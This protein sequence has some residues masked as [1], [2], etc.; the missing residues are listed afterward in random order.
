MATEHS[1]TPDNVSTSHPQIKLASPAQLHVPLPRGHTHTNAVPHLHPL[2]DQ[3]VMG[4]CRKQA[5]KHN[6]KTI[7]NLILINNMHKAFF[8]SNKAKESSLKEL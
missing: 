4:K 6:A 2:T 1:G 7:W 3:Y 5:T 8:N